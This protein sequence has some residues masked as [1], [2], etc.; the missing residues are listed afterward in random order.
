MDRRKFFKAT[1]LTTAGILGCPTFGE[2]M[3]K[4][5]SLMSK[6]NDPVSY[7]V[8]IDGNDS[9]SGTEA[10]PF[11]SIDRAIKAVRDAKHRHAVVSAL[12]GAAS[13][14][15]DRRARLSR[16]QANPARHR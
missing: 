9:N 8:A 11:A 14:T 15:G 7:Y 3:V 2:S 1:C 12:L 16:R 10:S 5:P 4:T 6:E 13:R